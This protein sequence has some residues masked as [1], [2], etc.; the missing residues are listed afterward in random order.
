[1]LGGAGRRGEHRTGGPLAAQESGRPPVV[2]VAGRGRERAGQQQDDGQQRRRESLR[3]SVPSC[4]KVGGATATIGRPRW[5]GSGRE[6]TRW[7]THPTARLQAALVSSLIAHSPGDAAAR[8]AAGQRVA[9]GWRVAQR[10]A[11]RPMAAGNG[12]AWRKGAGSAHRDVH[13]GRSRDLGVGNP[14][15]IAARSP[16][17]RRTEANAGAGSGVLALER[18]SPAAVSGAIQLR[19]ERAA[20]PSPLDAGGRRDDNLTEVR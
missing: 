6:P 4:S 17:S 15:G 19:A 1:V 5:L 18:S 10:G 20:R 14:G 8:A 13:P 9:R 16:R 12:Q 7:Q 3:H 2:G 11:H